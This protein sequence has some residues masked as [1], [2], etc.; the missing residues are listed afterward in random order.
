[1]KWLDFLAC[2]RCNGELVQVTEGL[3][4]VNCI[5]D[6]WMWHISEDIARL[7][8][9]PSE[10]REYRFEVERYNRIARQLPKDYSGHD[11][12]KP[13]V[14]A[15]I[16]K[17]LIGNQPLYLNI[18]PGFGHLEKQ[19]CAATKVCL[20][21]SIEFLRLLDRFLYPNIWF[22][23]AFAERM[24]FKTEFFPCVVS[25]SVW[26]VAVDQKEYFIENA[27]VLKPGGTFI[28]AIN[29]RW[30]YP[31][32]PQMFPV[33][34]PSLLLHFLDELGVKAQAEYYDL[35]SGQPCKYEKGQYQVIMGIKQ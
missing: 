4:C 31:R 1:M 27:R 11:E 21:Q 28:A 30:N 24:P 2:P 7:L 6:P 33:D 9:F 10:K 23:N 3:Y 19:M 8:E 18:G 15:Q 32:K 22:V 17:E 12:S 29:Y 35:E 13:E 34:D 14:R 16:I 20:D 5:N 26:T 25:D